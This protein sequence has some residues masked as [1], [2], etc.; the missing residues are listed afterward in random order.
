MTYFNKMCHSF[1]TSFRRRS[2][3]YFLYRPETC[4]IKS[5]REC[6][7]VRCNRT[8]VLLRPRATRQFV[9]MNGNEGRIIEQCY[10][11]GQFLRWNAQRI[12]CQH[13]EITYRRFGRQTLCFVHDTR[14]YHWRRRW[15]WTHQITV[16]WKATG[17]CLKEM[18]ID[19]CR[20][21]LLNDWQNSAARWIVSSSNKIFA[22]WRLFLITISSKVTATILWFSVCRFGTWR[23]R[24][25]FVLWCTF[26][27][28][29]RW[30]S[31]G[32]RRIVTKCL[33]NLF[34]A[35]LNRDRI[36]MCHKM[37]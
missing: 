37:R 20:W 33:I 12:H 6:N 9:W 23:R 25:V 13:I 34:F 15:C 10:L 5:S 4:V 35:K 22:V 11:T 18:L 17:R 1:G 28:M 30:L 14:R 21:C 8:F 29:I 2:T 3:E 31:F 26:W 7:N 27:F 32:N 24:K 36:E 16:I 19:Q